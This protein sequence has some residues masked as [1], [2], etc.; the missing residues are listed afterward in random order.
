MIPVELID[1][2]REATDIVEVVSAHVQLK[3]SGKSYKG[4]CPFHQEKTPS[5]IVNPDRQ[6]FKCFGCGAGGNAFHFLMRIEGLTFVEAVRELAR[7]AKIALPDVRSEAGEARDRERR[8]LLD[9]TAWAAARFVQALQA[10]KIS[11]SVKSY[12]RQRG[13]SDEL[14]ERFGLG[15]APPGWDNLIK[16][17][18]R[19]HYSEELLLKAGLIQAKSEERGSYD[20]FRDRLMFPIRD[21]QGRP[22]AFGGRLLKPG[23]PKYLNSPET[24]IFRKG[25]VLYALDLAREA[26][27]RQG[28]LVLVEGYLDAIACHGAGVAETVATMGTALTPHQARLLRRYAGKLI[29][30][31]DSDEAGVNASLR[32]FEILQREGLTML[33]VSLPDAKDPDEYIHRFGADA[34]RQALDRAEDMMSFVLNAALKKHDVKT[35]EGKLEVVREAVPFIALF[36]DDRIEDQVKRQ[37][38]C[39]MLSER[40]RLDAGQILK[41]VN[42]EAKRRAGKGTGEARGPESDD[43]KGAWRKL[44]QPRESTCAEAELLLG[45]LLRFPHLIPAAGERMDPEFFTTPVLRQIARM[46]LET[47]APG[48]DDAESWL[49]RLL[50]RCDDPALGETIAGLAAGDGRDG[51]EDP[52]AAL[53]RAKQAVEDCLRRLEAA[54]L[55]ERIAQVQWQIREADRNGELETLKHLQQQEIQWKNQLKRLGVDWRLA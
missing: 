27:R 21:A 37:E 29:L 35:V 52:E 25:E 49:P 53:N 41:L 11:A 7:R 51:D 14:C 36:R 28:R 47:P 34:F 23:E 9:V 17:A 10:P 31:Y 45:T 39:R 16:A 15:F 44:A 8:Q 55:R 26:A 33:V 20:R 50:G 12:L 6:I 1:R 30:I 24:D 5:F 18:R 4:L 42:Q 40:L 32:A 54:R 13:V 43:S 19:D 48:A 46:V 3:S 22:V 38:Y 2:I